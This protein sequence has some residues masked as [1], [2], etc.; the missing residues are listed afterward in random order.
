MINLI[1][2]GYSKNTDYVDIISEYYKRLG[3][4]LKI[5]E[6][7][8][9][10]GSKSEI[11]QKE[12][13]EIEKYSNSDFRIFLDASKG[14]NLSSDEFAKKMDNWLSNNRNIS[15]IIGG[16]FGFAENLITKN[17]YVLS[18]GNMTF[19]HMMARAILLEQIY[20]SFEIFKNS[21]YHK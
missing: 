6:L 12:A 19:P 21:P 7:A 13:K 5:I 4:K 9:A 1:C 16:S 8:Q 3:N 2:F 14:Q 15:F 17:D 18:L 10:K 20:R 11:L